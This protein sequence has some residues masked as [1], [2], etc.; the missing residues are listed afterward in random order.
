MAWL[1]RVILLTCHVLLTRFKDLLLK[2][3]FCEKKIQPARTRFGCYSNNRDNS[4]HKLW[5]IIRPS[6]TLTFQ[7]WEHVT[8]WLGA[9]SLL[10]FLATLQVGCFRIS[11]YIPDG[12]LFSNKAQ[13]SRKIKLFLVVSVLFCNLVWFSRTF[14]ECFTSKSMY[15]VTVTQID[16]KNILRMFSR[17]R[18]DRRIALT[19]PERVWFSAYSALYLIKFHSTWEE[20]F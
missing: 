11:R 9:Q 6:N 16:T 4:I 1:V 17:I 13:S 8:K 12:F 20:I 18:S 3:N 14:G 19:P 2:K 5:T 15:I 7:T 10:L